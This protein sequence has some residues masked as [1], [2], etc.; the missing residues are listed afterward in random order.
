MRIGLA[1]AGPWATSVCVPGLQRATNVDLVAVWDDRARLGHRVDGVGVGYYSDFDEFLERVDA[2]AFA[3]PPDVQAR[4]AARAAS[5]GKHLLLELPMAGSVKNAT[6]LVRAVE[7]SGVFSIVFF[8][9]RFTM[10]GRHW[11]SRVGNAGGWTGGWCHLFSSLDHPDNPVSRSMWRRERDAL[12]DIAPQVVS[13]FIAT[14]GPVV[15]ASAVSGD[16]DLVHLVMSH[17]SGATSTASMT[18]RAP[19][20]ANIAELHVWG[21]NGFS[22][23]PSRSMHDVVQA[24]ATAGSELAQAL[25]TGTPHDVDARFGAEVLFWLEQAVGDLQTPR[26]RRVAGPP[27]GA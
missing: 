9:D 27:L 23:M 15:S 12:W 21:R 10:G 8:A 4:L 17:Q 26:A 11:L 2:V 19:P 20:A 5:H 6:K 7:Q 13:M 3:L 24:M 14:L 1:G 18:L 16:R 25:A 22:R